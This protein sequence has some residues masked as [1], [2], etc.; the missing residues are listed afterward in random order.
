[1]LKRPRP[2]SLWLFP[3]RN[4][5]KHRTRQAVFKDLQRA[6]KLFRLDGKRIKAHISPHTARKIYAVN[7]YHE[8]EKGGLLR[9]LEAVMVDLNHENPAVTVLYALADQLSQKNYP[10]I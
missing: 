10:K 6:A 2:K 9:P 8:K 5:E 1:M 7:L 3:G 4:P